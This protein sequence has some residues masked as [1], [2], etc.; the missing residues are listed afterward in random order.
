MYMLEEKDERR[1]E[2]HNEVVILLREH[3]IQ[4]KRLWKMERLEQ[5]K[6]MEKE[7]KIKVNEGGNVKNL[8]IFFFFDIV[9]YFFFFFFC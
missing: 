1:M 7:N 5:E 9:C 2:V 6:N 4:L 8:S 3:I